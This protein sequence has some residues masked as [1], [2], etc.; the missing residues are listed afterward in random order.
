MKIKDGTTI[1]EL[2]CGKIFDDIIKTDTLSPSKYKLYCKDTTYENNVLTNHN[3]LIIICEN[4]DYV[5]NNN[6]KFKTLEIIEKD[7]YIEYNFY[8]MMEGKKTNNRYLTAQFF[9]FLY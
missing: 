4:D 7:N 3:S 2:I 1:N 8:S 5:V 9:N 6:L